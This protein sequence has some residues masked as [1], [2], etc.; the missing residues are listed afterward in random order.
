[1]QLKNKQTTT[2]KKNPNKQPK[3]KKQTNN[4]KQ[5]CQAWPCF[6]TSLC[7]DTALLHKEQFDPNPKPV[8]RRWTWNNDNPKCT[9]AAW[10]TK[11]QTE[12]TAQTAKQC[13]V[14]PWHK[15]HVFHND[16]CLSRMALHEQHQIANHDKQDP[17]TFQPNVNNNTRFGSKQPNK[18]TVKP[19]T[20]HRHT[21]YPR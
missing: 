5:T 18:P 13:F 15:C 19:Q 7:E 8:K 10:Q 14:Q 3:Q 21:L 17:S 4:Q 12:H 11:L 16:F 2:T 6:T 20:H 9:M 1:M